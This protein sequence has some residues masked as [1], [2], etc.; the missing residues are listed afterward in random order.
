M[1]LNYSLPYI[2]VAGLMTLMLSGCSMMPGEDGKERAALRLQVQSLE[3]RLRALEKK[4]EQVSVAVAKARAAVAFVWGSYTF[5]DDAGRPLRHVLDEAGEPISDAQGVPLVDVTGTGSVAVTGYCG[6][7]FLVD[8]K[9]SLLTNRHVAEPWW[10]DES[11]APLLAAGLRPV[12]IQLRA[13]F[14]ERSDGVPIEVLRVDTELDVALARTF[15]WI[16]DAEPLGAHPDSERVREGQ[17]VFLVGYPTGLDAVV[18]RLDYK[19]QA[20]LE[21]ATGSSDYAKALLLAQRQQLRPSITGGFLWEVLPH[22]LVYDAHTTGGSSGG[23]VLDRQGR[24]IAINAAYLSGF[25]GINYG[26]P[27]KVGQELLQGRGRTAEGP[28]RETPKIIQESKG[29]HQGSLTTPL[30]RP[31]IPAPRFSAKVSP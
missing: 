16:P 31:S 12:F 21:K 1:R 23:P 11:S 27:I 2:L 24:V 18:A 30:H 20:E 15:G 22:T 8:G 13:F 10:E 28:T 6:T 3:A 4:Q 17:P 26:I 19:E 7:A 9:G 14:Q 5:V 25:R 29:N